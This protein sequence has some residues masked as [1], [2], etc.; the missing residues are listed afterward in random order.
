MLLSLLQKILELDGKVTLFL[1]SIVPHNAFFDAIFYFFAPKGISFFFWIA[2]FLFLV[3]FEEKRHKE[4]IIYF[5]I[6]I[7]ISLIFSNLIFKPLFARPRPTV[8][9]ICPKDFSFPSGHTTLSF[10]AAGILSYFDRKRKF[11]YYFFATLV[12]YSRIYLG[13]HYLLD[14]IGGIILAESINYLLLTFARRKT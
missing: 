13:C 8:S 14:I 5:L 9:A 11:I 3:I 7:T 4:F 10:A 2:I 1:K 12:G 6:S